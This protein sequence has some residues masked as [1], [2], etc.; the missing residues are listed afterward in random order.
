MIDCSSACRGDGEM[1]R[2]AARLPPIAY[3]QRAG[4]DRFLSHEAVKHPILFTFLQIRTGPVGLR[5]LLH[6]V[7]VQCSGHQLGP[8]E[9]ASQR[10]SDLVRM[11]THLLLESPERDLRWSMTLN[12]AWK[13]PDR[14][15]KRKGGL[16][17]A[18]FRGL[19]SSCS[20]A[21]SRAQVPPQMTSPAGSCGAAPP[22]KARCL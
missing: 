14:N 8:G 10:I 7:L 5:A 3:W 19:T 2:V 18:G 9:G 11:G 4:L 1:R 21:P 20:C 6:L 16:W 12:F 13:T 17:S 22:P 15:L